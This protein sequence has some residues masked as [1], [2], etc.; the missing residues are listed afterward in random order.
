M[1][2]ILVAEDDSGTRRL[3][4]AALRHKGHNVI[5]A[6]EGLGA[7]RMIELRAPDLIVSDVNMPGMTGFALLQRLR[8]HPSLALT[9]FILLTSLRERSDMRHGM[10]TGADD[11]LTKPLRHKELIEIGRAHV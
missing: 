2:L 9:P 5:N 1:A 8:E 10:L 7:W 3:I 4:T 11:Y 6:S